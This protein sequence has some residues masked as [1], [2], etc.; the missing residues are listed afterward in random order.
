MKIQGFSAH[1]NLN[2]SIFMRWQ[3]EFKY[4]LLKYHLSS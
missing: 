1:Q 3:R 2:F 4:K